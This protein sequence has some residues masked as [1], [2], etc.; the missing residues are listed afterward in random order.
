MSFQELNLSPEWRKMVSKRHKQDFPLFPC[1][2][3]YF[4]LYTAFKMVLFNTK[5]INLPDVNQYTLLIIVVI[6]TRRK[7]SSHPL[8]DYNPITEA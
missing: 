2:F 6:L 3:I 7:K 4:K 5:S 8:S 1:Y